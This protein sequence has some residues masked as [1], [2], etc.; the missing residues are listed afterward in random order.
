MVK[1]H[2]SLTLVL[3]VDER[4][5]SEETRLEIKRCW[6]HVGSTVVRKH[7]A[8]SDAIVNTAQFLVKMGTTKYLR[9]ADAGAD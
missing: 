1:P 9:S 5:A 4:V 3:D 7:A 6:A 2:P 8:T